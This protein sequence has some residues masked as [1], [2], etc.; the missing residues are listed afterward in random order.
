MLLAHEVGI[1]VVRKSTTRSHGGST[2]SLRQH[3]SVGRARYWVSFKMSTY[4]VQDRSKMTVLVGGLTA[5]ALGVPEA[6]WTGNA[7]VTMF[8]TSGMNDSIN[9]GEVRR[10]G[11]QTIN[12]KD[13]AAC[14]STLE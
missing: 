10:T 1:T 7:R 13:T 8:A 2:L 14:P 3:T 12:N 5:L 11:R 4:A 6:Q 9:H